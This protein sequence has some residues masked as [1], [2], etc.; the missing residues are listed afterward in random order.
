MGQPHDSSSTAVD[1]TLRRNLPHLALARQSTAA[2]DRGLAMRRAAE[3]PLAA[4]AATSDY[5][6]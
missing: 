4:R 3:A 1:A 5:E 6:P 2:I